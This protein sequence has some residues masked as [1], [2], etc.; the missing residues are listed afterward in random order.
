MSHLVEG[1][2]RGKH[3]V[4]MRKFDAARALEL[5]TRHR[6]HF[7]LFVP[8]KMHRI[9]QLP[10]EVRQRA[11]MRSLKRVW[12]TAAPCPPDLKRKWTTGSAG[13]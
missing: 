12:H 11:D 6:P 7:A 10:E 3:V 13:T 5:I 8:T 1:L 9:M 2:A 4:F